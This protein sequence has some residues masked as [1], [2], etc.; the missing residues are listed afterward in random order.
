MRE[1]VEGLGED[2]FGRSGG[3]VHR[4][5]FGV[6]GPDSDSCFHD[7][8]LPFLLLLVRNPTLDP[9]QDRKPPTRPLNESGPSPSTAQTQFESDRIAI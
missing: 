1:T 9:N 6:R 8:L 2:F 3:E 4:D 5:G 7:V